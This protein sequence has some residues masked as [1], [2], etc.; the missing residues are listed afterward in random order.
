MCL[1]LSSIWFLERW[2][3]LFVVFFYIK[4][5]SLKV[6]FV[7]FCCVVFWFYFLCCLCSLLKWFWNTDFG[8]LDT[9][10]LTCFPFFFLLM[11]M[12]SAARS[13]FLGFDWCIRRTPF[14]GFSPIQDSALTCE[15][16]YMDAKLERT[17]FMLNLELVLL[18]G[19]SQQLVAFLGKGWNCFLLILLYTVG[20]IWF[21]GKCYWYCWK[22]GCS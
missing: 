2:S 20:Q 6:G 11:L 13:G 15:L 3:I 12:F 10:S 4:G 16:E 19:W 21:W 14:A 1:V 22:M 7:L 18:W 5:V 9:M 17:G 8:F